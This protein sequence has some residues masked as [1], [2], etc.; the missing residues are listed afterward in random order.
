MYC[1]L[2]KG[3][4]VAVIVPRGAKI[5]SVSPFSQ[6]MVFAKVEAKHYIIQSD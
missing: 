3:K 2:H 5:L 4:H 6:Y 1:G